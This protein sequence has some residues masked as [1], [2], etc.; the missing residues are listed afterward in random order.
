M[1]GLN[2]SQ[3]SRGEK[4]D[5][6]KGDNT[7]DLLTEQGIGDCR[8]PVRVFVLALS[9]TSS[10]YFVNEYFCWNSV[11]IIPEQGVVLQCQFARYLVVIP[12]C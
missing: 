1:I 8:A 9:R 3:L 11:G 5:T 4:S 6:S 2:R 7:A 10:V 12:G